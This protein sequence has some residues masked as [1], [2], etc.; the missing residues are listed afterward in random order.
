MRNQ[1]DNVIPT[2]KWS[3][4]DEVTNC[5]GD[6]LHRSIPAYEIMRS[7]TFMLGFSFVTTGKSIIDLGCSTGLGVDP[8][9]DSFGSRNKYILVDES[10]SM[11]NHCKEKY[12]YLIDAGVVNV[13]HRNICH[14]GIPH[15]S[16]VS[17]IL[18]ILTIQFTPIEY[19]QQLL[20]QVYDR[21]EDGGAFIFVE[22]ILGN[23]AENNAMLVDSYY[24]IKEQNGYTKEAINAK[25]RSLEGV[26]VPVTYEANES[27]LKSAGFNRVECFWRC[28]NFCGWIAIK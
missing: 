8:F 25:R 14:D 5:F 21:L 2:S 9:I 13:R 1:K 11:A 28:L 19:R 26:L 18:S 7:L 16:N 27:F 23:S 17:L 3:F 15:S 12:K 22:K 24:A 20:K 4:S 6:M 10:E